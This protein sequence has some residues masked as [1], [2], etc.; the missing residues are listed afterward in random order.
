MFN[1]DKFEHEAAIHMRGD[2]NYAFNPVEAMDR[3]MYYKDLRLIKVTYDVLNEHGININCQGYTYIRDAV[4]MIV[5]LKSMDV[6]LSKEIYPYI[7]EKYGLSS[8]SSVERC[9]RYAVNSA[10]K[11]G[12]M[13]GTARSTLDR[14]MGRPT[15]KTFILMVVQEVSGRLLAELE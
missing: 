13:H 9:I 3:D 6:C 12:M 14:L 15:N 7:A 1:K 11:K 4:W 2:Y 8:V 5:D 10:Y